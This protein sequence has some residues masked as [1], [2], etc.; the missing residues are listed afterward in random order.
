MKYSV[1]DV[2]DAVDTR[3]ALP[4][5]HAA[6][7]QLARER[8]DV[9]GYIARGGRAYGFTTFFGHLDDRDATAEDQ[10]TLLDYHLVGKPQVLDERRARG[11][12]AVKLCQLSHG[13][14]G[15]S[16]ALYDALLAAWE[17]D[18]D[19]I[20]VDLTAS[21]GSGDVVVGSQMLNGLVQD[22]PVELAAGDVMAF[23]NGSWVGAGVAV[24]DF[25][26]VS[27][28][29]FVARDV[30]QRASAMAGSITHV[31][32]PVTVRDA[33][34]LTDVVEG[35]VEALAQALDHSM[36]NPS[37]N[38]RFVYDK[39]GELRAV[40]TSQFLNF[41]LGQAHSGVID[42][43]RVA[44][45]Y[46]VG[47]TRWAAGAYESMSTSAADAARFVQYPKVSKGY[48][49]HTA[50][51]ACAPTY[52]QA[53]SVGTEDIG[54]MTCAKACSLAPLVEIV[55]EQTRLATGVLDALDSALVSVSASD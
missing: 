2:V 48:Y 39:S 34:P 51:S 35:S 33:N 44:S 28:T 9:N 43:L 31:Q 11:L 49:D 19:D 47:V 22:T 18:L 14:S 26:D 12:L 30:T 42:A 46:L 17:S 38:P 29:L 41:R 13:G 36:N 3:D 54:D 50:D 23:I 20:A 25:I 1:E 55:T 5:W 16:P 53:E 7:A 21:Y 24:A 8:D 6:R 4:D 45:A 37:A 15:A 27:R 52:A 10:R 40:S 32:A